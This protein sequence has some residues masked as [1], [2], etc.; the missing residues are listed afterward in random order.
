[1]T[2]DNASNDSITHRIIAT[3]TDS[4]AK[5]LVFQN[6]EPLSSLNDNGSPQS[7]KARE[8]EYWADTRFGIG[9]GAWFTSVLNT[10][11]DTPTLPELQTILLSMFNRLRTF[12]LPK[13]ADV[14]DSLVFHEGWTPEESNLTL[15]C[16]LQLATLLE[17]VRDSQLIAAGT[18][19]G[20][21]TNYLFRKFKV[22]PTSA[23]GA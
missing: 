12:T 9:L 17:T 13:G 4:P 21:V 11:T 7:L 15:L 22:L 2:V 20:V 19:G 6:R 8:T 16:S 10:L 5:P 18:G 23:L 14:D 3:I 1:M